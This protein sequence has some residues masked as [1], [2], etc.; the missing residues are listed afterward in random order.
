MKENNNEK[1]N[2]NKKNANLED[3]KT[4]SSNLNATKFSNG[5]GDFRELN[6]EIFQIIQQGGN[7]SG[8]SITNSSLNNNS[9]NLSN[10]DNSNK[11]I[12]LDQTMKKILKMILLRK[13]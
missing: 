12:S 3:K 6:K 13:K 8:L 1:N 9:I 2:D 5:S 4:N 11:K 7:I 10:Q